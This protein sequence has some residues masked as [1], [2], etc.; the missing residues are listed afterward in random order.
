M[1]ALK[2]NCSE[3]GRTIY[4]MRRFTFTKK[5]S[6]R[7]VASPSVQKPGCIQASV[8]KVKT[9]GSSDLFRSHVLF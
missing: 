6:A 8:S 4:M 5:P 3:Y 2:I 9:D 7:F 1:D